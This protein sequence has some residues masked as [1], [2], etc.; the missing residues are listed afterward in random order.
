MDSRCFDNAPTPNPQPPTLSPTLPHP[1]N[2]YF[3][4]T[5][6]RHKREKFH[7]YVN[8]ADVLSF[9]IWLLRTYHNI[10]ALV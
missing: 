1:F 4:L 6:L 10:S 7:T 3:L 8:L 2:L 5:L 9:D